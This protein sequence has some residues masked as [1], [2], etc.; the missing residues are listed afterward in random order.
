MV[1]KLGVMFSKVN[2][3]KTLNRRNPTPTRSTPTC[4]TTYAILPTLPVTGC[5]PSCTA[6]VERS[7]APLD[8]L[9]PS[10]QAGS[11]PLHNRQERQVVEGVQLAKRQPGAHAGDPKRL[12]DQHGQGAEAQ[13]DDVL[14]R[15][16]SHQVGQLRAQQD[17][18]CG[19][20]EDR[21]DGHRQRREC[22]GCRG[23][24]NKE[25]PG[26]LAGP[27][28]KLASFIC[29]DAR[30]SCACRSASSRSASSRPAA[31]TSATGCSP[32]PA[33]CTSCPDV[34]RS[35]AVRAAGRVSQSLGLRA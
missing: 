8:R 35:V 6:F 1:R 20:H 18:E 22:S 5:C 15:P 4:H 14:G 11:R 31:A 29:C 33:C 26:Q 34:S 24:S 28:L 10:G 21:R 30:C 23:G 27:L 3:A 12:A 25:R 17:Q 19:Q 32:R 2:E 9:L 16:G 7:N 13:P